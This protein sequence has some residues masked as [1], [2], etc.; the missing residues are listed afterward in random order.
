MIRRLLILVVLAAAAGGALLFWRAG[1][2]A[3]EVK[4]IE[5][6]RGDAA[7]VVYATGMWSPRNGRR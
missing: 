4:L 3:P 2:F 5:A 6:R 1:G 7:E